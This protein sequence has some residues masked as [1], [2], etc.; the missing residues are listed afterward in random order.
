MRITQNGFGVPQTPVVPSMKYA[1]NS[2]PPKGTFREP[3]IPIR[4]L[5]V[6][7]PG[8]KLPLGNDDNRDIFVKRP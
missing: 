1:L 6:L 8:A 5:S 4:S 7:K 3:G 2:E